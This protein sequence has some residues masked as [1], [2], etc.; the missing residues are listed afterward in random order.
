MIAK[1]ERKRREIWADLAEPSSVIAFLALYCAI[2][3]LVRYLLSPNFTLDESEQMLFGQSLEWGYRFRHPPLITWLSWG[4]L[5]ATNNSRA[6]FFLLKYLIMAGGLVAYFA[7][8]RIVI[9]DVRMATLA[10]FGLLTTFVIGFLP[11]VDLMH[12][13]LLTTM[14]AAFLWI[15]ERILTKGTPRDYL[16]LAAIT[17]L[18]I[19]SKYVFLV[20]PVAFAV[21]VTLTPRFRARIKI[22]PLIL[23]VILALAIVAPYAWWSYTHEY[24]LFALAKTI[25]KGQGPEFS[26]VN[27]LIG[28][29]DLVWALISFGLPFVVIFPLL[30]R[31]ACKK[32]AVTDPDDR[33]WL[34]LYEITMIAGVLMMLVAV[35]FVG[36]EAFKARWMHQVAMPLPIYLFLRARIAVAN[37]RANRIFAAIALVFA[38]LVVGARVYIYETHAKNCKEC[39][40]YWPMQ[41]YARAFQRSGFDHGTILAETYDLGGNLRG[42]FPQSRVVTP[43]Y[44]VQVF[45][46][47]V[48]GP[49]LLVWEGDRAP[50][51]DLTGYLAANYGATINDA[52]TRGDVN[53]ALLTSKTRRD[54]M[55]YVLI[56]KGRCAG[57]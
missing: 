15:G 1:A 49:C 39:R 27:W 6:A 34:R 17:G 21:G 20:L 10:T 24:S 16:L 35:F 22:G 37:D 12:T 41:S 7:A 4:T 57:P 23:A 33:D 45:G 11:H 32:I 29:G 36:T 53:A 13:V 40:E 3:F 47:P 19:L 55:N 2:H 43:G 5:A 51:K 14:L 38:L 28:T 44:P 42:V 25:T 56:R 46:P 48:A 52:A 54:T 30:Y 8:A 9:R 50:S 18:G 31:P 26:P